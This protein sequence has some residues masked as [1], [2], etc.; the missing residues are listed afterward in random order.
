MVE[1]QVGKISHYFSKV[2]VA[3]V[4]LGADLKVGD[5]IAIVCKDGTR[6]QQP[7]AS[8]QIDKAPIQAAR[9]GQ[10]IGL[11]VAERVHEGDAVL[12]IA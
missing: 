8:M 3:V 6:V 5:T 7:V 2:G 1:T 11:K 9:K 12:K 4:E 10:S